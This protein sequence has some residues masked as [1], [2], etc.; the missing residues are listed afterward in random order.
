MFPQDCSCN[1]WLAFGEKHSTKLLWG[2]LSFDAWRLSLIEARKI[3]GHLAKKNPGS[4]KDG[5]NVQ[6]WLLLGF[7]STSANDIDDFSV[8][9]V[10]IFIIQSA[11]TVCS[12][13]ICSWVFEVEFVSFSK[14]DDPMI[15]YEPRYVLISWLYVNIWRRNL[16]SKWKLS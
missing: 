3:H 5:K 1:S 4:F 12:N 8:K 14:C 9:F 13:K 6:K 2:F 16:K 7:S 11:K 15:P 10:L